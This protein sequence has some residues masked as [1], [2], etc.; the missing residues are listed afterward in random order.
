[1]KDQN[2][3]DVDCRATESLATNVLRDKTFAVDRHPLE[4]RV[5][6][7]VAKGDAAGGDDRVIHNDRLPTVP[8]VPVAENPH[9]SPAQPATHREI[10]LD[11]NTVELG[12][13]M[14]NSAI[15]KKDLW[16]H[17]QKLS[18]TR[19][20][21]AR[22]GTMFNY[23]IDEDGIEL[24]AKDRERQM[25]LVRKEAEWKMEMKQKMLLWKKQNNI[26]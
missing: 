15:G 6:P 8:G 16:E 14:M 12:G 19:N 2:A 25:E 20:K 9:A 21:C 1:M 10:E 4:I 26:A 22:F 5:A 7:E 3:V 23:R 17:V 13:Q 11:N 18:I 24:T